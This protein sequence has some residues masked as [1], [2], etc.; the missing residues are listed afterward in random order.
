MLNVEFAM[1]R[2]YGYILAVFFPICRVHNMILM[3]AEMPSSR[4][5]KR[6]LL[7]HRIPNLREPKL[8]ICFDVVV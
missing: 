6:M 7:H 3:L 8:V 2:L 4:G 5:G 1:R